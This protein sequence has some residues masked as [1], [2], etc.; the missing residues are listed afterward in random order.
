MNAIDLGTQYALAEGRLVAMAADGKRAIAGD[1]D[2][3]RF[4][5]GQAV[6]SAAGVVGA[7]VLDGAVWI[8]TEDRGEHTLHRFDHAGASMGPPAALGALGEDVTLEVT[9]R[10]LRSALIEGERGLYVREEGER[11]TTDELGRWTRDRR[12]LMGG[13]GVMERRDG[14]LVFR[15]PGGASLALPRDL[16]SGRV[17]GGALVLDGAAALIEIEAAGERTALTYHLARG[18]LRSRARLGEGRILAVAERHGM[19]VLGRGAHVAL[20]DLRAGCCVGERAFASPPAAAAIDADATRLLVIDARGEICEVPAGIAAWL[21]SAR[22]AAHNGN[23]AVAAA[24]AEAETQAGSGVG[25]EAGSEAASKAGSGTGSDAGSSA[26]SAAEAANDAETANDTGVANGCA[27]AA[28]RLDGERGELAEAAALE[29]VALG[30]ARRH[31]LGRDELDEYL[32]DVRAW[33]SSLCR[34]AVAGAPAEARAE[35]RA[36]AERL[37]RWR[38]REVPHVEIARELGLS[39]LAAT[40]LLVVAA[41]QIWG[42]LARAYGACTAEPGRSLVDELLLAQLFEA[43]STLMR[44]A[45]GRELD[46]DAP[47]VVTG[48]IEV[49]ASVRPYAALR[50]HP[51]ITR[52]LAGAPSASDPAASVGATPALPDLIGPRA[53]IADLAQRLARPASGPARV[54]LRG[55]AGAGRRTLAAALAAQAGRALAV[56]ALDGASGELEARLRQRLRDAALRGDVPCVAIDGLA[57]DPAVRSR[58]RAVLDAHPGPVFVRAPRGG[59]LPLS[60][61]YHAVDFA[62]LTETERKAAW[63]RTLFTHALDTAPAGALAARFSVGPGAMHRACAAVA[64]GPAAA[65]EPALAAAVRQHRSARIEAIATRVERLASWDDLIVPDDIAEVLHELCARVHHRR[66]VIEDWGLRGVAATARAVTALFQGG[67]GTGKTMAAEVV[68]RALDYELWRVDL[69]KVVSK[70]IGETEKNLAAVFD[71]A[72]DGE[73]VLLFDEADSLF[74]KR[75][76]VKSSHDRNA[77]LETNYLLQRLDTFTGIAILTTNLGTA[78]DPAFR[79]R[80]SVQV[81]FPFPDE[82]DRERLWRAHL[83]RTVPT[84]GELDLGDLARRFQLTGGYIRNAVL[85]A[86]YLAASRGLPLSAADLE[87]A[88]QAE[89]FAN[90]KISATGVLG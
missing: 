5:G 39:Q 85:R 82:Q 20:L 16:A 87:R 69:S 18:A 79:R 31:A 83:P 33:V 6:M 81:Q 29:L 48:T 78:I 63:E 10:G 30:P 67:P 24:E 88:V 70:W 45:I 61:G 50:V 80:L 7:A 57:D 84:A 64:V 21:S 90:G 36:A 44:T 58:L 26:G 2:L 35:E 19:L 54:V 73:I 8:V 22:S 52:R 14:A 15:R 4:V 34:R 13:R 72:E 1:G 59:E 41:P 11:I 74:G 12:V 55:R 25:S 23:A 76:E 3:I 47:L 75:T 71:A 62:P 42:E 32:D 60:P 49:D 65:L 27:S 56:I 37:A 89:Y 9:R 68:A 46:D 86:A 17:V 77:N 66:T 40:V 28:A 38:H 43:G 51:A 53:A